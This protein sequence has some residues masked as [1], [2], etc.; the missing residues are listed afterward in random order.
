MEKRGEGCIYIY[1]V[2][3]VHT[4]Q[5]WRTHIHV[6]AIMSEIRY[7]LDFKSGCSIRVRAHVGRSQV[8]L[9]KKLSYTS[10]SY[11]LWVEWTLWRRWR[12][13]LLLYLEVVGSSPREPRVR[14][15]FTAVRIH[16]VPTHTGMLV[17]TRYVRKAVLCAY[18]C[19]YSYCSTSVIY[20]RLL[21]RRL[22]LLF[23]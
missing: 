1:P 3:Q 22:S 16:M 10:M 6:H 7:P 20:R 11:P 23:S 12:I 4:Y 14:V 15:I 18:C 2:H 17:C 9:P 19:M 21:L 8:S 5:M 13:A